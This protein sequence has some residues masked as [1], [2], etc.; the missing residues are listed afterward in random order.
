M[1]F[2]P[3]SFDPLGACRFCIY[4]SGAPDPDTLACACPDVTGRG[5]PPILASA[6]RS[7]SGACGPEPRHFTMRDEVKFTP[8]SMRRVYARER[9]HRPHWPATFEDAMK[10]PL[11]SRIIET[12]A[13][14]VPAVTR[15]RADRWRIGVNGRRELIAPELEPA[16]DSPAAIV[17]ASN[18]YPADG[19]K[20]VQAVGV[21]L[22][23]R[24]S[25]EKD[26][27]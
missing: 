5:N 25:G 1:S 10:D 15:R 24:A 4:R 13:L 22:K 9:E 7:A 14:H 23:R 8:E 26:D 21:D 12:M 19:F 18:P 20:R 27:E 17:R 11:V 16:D 3:F 2:E 6:A